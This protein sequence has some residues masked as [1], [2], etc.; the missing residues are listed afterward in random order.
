MYVCMYIRS[1]ESS[2]GFDHVIHTY[3][4]LYIHTLGLMSLEKRLI[5]PLDF[6]TQAI[7]PF[8]FQVVTFAGR[9]FFM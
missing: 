1:K 5:D 4:H 7:R 6:I 3:I 8:Q 2:I 9:V